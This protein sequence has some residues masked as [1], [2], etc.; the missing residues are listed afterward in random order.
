MGWVSKRGRPVSSRTVPSLLLLGHATFLD[1]SS[2]AAAIC[3]NKTERVNTGGIQPCRVNFPLD[4]GA[5]GF[6]LA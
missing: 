5:E 1:R 6:V 2:C 3:S 4:F